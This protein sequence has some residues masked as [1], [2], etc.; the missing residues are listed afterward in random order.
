MQL[1]I[2]KNSNIEIFFA[3][4]IGSIVGAAFGSLL[5][6][7]ISDRPVPETWLIMS[8]DGTHQL[9]HPHKGEGILIVPN[10]TDGGDI[11]YVEMAVPQQQS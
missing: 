3:A 4:G 10:D 6:L 7:A 8:P 1:P 9:A 2:S 11:Q 5:M